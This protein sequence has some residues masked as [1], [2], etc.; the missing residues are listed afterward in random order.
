MYKKLI[1][2]EETEKSAVGT[3]G[4]NGNGAKPILINQIDSKDPENI[5]ALREMDTMEKI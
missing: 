5:D 1:L 4:T 2:E 3:N